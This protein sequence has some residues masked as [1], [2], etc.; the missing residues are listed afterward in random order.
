MKRDSNGRFKS[1]KGL[2]IPLPSISV[3]ITSFTLIFF[4][5]PWIYAGL[6]L[7]VIE[8]IFNIL[9]TIFSNCQCPNA[10][11]GTSKY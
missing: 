8:K 3:I 9:S 7:N 4:L 2:V 5:I 1:S 11:E 6:R 10:N